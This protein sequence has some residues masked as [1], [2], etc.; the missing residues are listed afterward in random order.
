[1]HP[2]LTTY[3]IRSGPWVHVDCLMPWRRSDESPLLVE[4]ARAQL[5][6]CVRVALF[7]TTPRDPLPPITLV[8]PVPPPGAPPET[9]VPELPTVIALAF[10]MALLVVLRLAL[11]T[12]RAWS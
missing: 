10:G 3:L 11:G 5:P 9:L 12:R 7:G 1:M 8:P 4:Q 2:L 6:T